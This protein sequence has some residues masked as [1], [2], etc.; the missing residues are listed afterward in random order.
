M[1]IGVNYKKE[2]LKYGLW[3]TIESRVFPGSV[4]NHHLGTQLALLMAAYEMNQFKDSY[5]KAIVENAKYFLP[6]A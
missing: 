3:E 1:V 5:Q 2:D 6:S 4:S